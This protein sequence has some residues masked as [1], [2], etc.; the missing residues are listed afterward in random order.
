MIDSNNNI[1]MNVVLYYIE[2]AKSYVI[3]SYNIR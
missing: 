2:L 3:E 1:N